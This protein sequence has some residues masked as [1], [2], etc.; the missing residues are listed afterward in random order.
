MISFFDLRETQERLM[1]DA[2]H[3]MVDDPLLV[4]FMNDYELSA[5]ESTT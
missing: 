3:S 5:H 4:P 1:V 2:I